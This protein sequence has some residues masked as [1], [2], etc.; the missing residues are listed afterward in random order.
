MSKKARGWGRTEVPRCPGVGDKVR[1]WGS[2]ALFYPILVFRYQ[3]LVASC[4]C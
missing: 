4:I 1:L 3:T 2:E